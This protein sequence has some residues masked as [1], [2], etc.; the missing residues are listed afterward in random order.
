MN[1]VLM[2]C[3]AICPFCVMAERL[4]RTKG[5][6]EIEKIRVDLDPGRRIEMMEKTRRR[7]VPQIYIGATHVG[8]F[9]ELA[10]L[11][12]A[13]ELDALLAEAG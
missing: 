12:H 1:K 3:T 9:D 4:L 2:Y 8:G 13:G 10:A 5:V 6:E 11:N 7:T